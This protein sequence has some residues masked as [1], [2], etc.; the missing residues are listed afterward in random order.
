MSIAYERQE[1]ISTTEAS[2]KLGEVLRHAKQKGRMILSK[3]NRLEAVILP[4][5]SYEEMI[6][7]LEHLLMAL[8]IQDRKARSS[9]KHITWES[10]KAKHGL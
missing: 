3:N 1:I 2:R 10:L 4:L 8:E 9:G 7:D 6:K 5:D